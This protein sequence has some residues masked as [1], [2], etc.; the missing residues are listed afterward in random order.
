MP[1]PT[2]PLSSID[3]AHFIGIG[4]IGVSAIA[5]LFLANG[6]AIS[7]SD[8]RLPS[9]SELPPG[10]TY[11]SG[12]DA[13][14]IPS[15]TKLVI[16]SPAV[17]EANPE[18]AR[19][20]ELGITEWSY[21]YALGRVTSA[22]ATI[23]VSGTHGKSTTTALLATM[24][25]DAGADPTAIVGAIVPEWKSNLR[26][27]KS[28]L[29]VVEACEYRRHMLE[30][31][32]QSIVLTN[33][34]LDHPDYYADLADVKRAFKEYIGKL[35][36]GGLLVYNADDANVRDV[37]RGSEA[38][39]VSYGVGEGADLVA[40]DIAE[41]E[42]EQTFSLTWKGSDLGTFR[43]PLPGLYNIYNILAATAA[44]LAYR[45]NT[46]SISTTIER[47]T[48]IGRR[49]EEIGKSREGTRIISDYAHHPTALKNVVAAA[50]TRDPKARLLVIF[51]PHQRE[52][53]LKLWDAFASA[54][55]KA[56]CQTFLLVE[57][58]AVPGREDA[59]EPCGTRLADAVRAIA[60]N[61]PLRFAP[62]LAEAETLARE[63]L[64]AHDI[65]LV[66]GAG[67]IHALAR[68]LATP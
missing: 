37:I 39:L 38:I 12:N 47:F 63:L 68:T 43:T 48:G 45:G 14:N 55:A 10:G 6:V 46:P 19:A 66:V 30:L 53:T 34:E 64:P 31:A 65:A 28:D 40:H 21:P 16:Y 23:A 4:G 8:V 51:Q 59:M 5:R 24:L 60:P 56:D 54:I 17:P 62:S 15:D 1:E 7:G 58:Y 11:F 33:I 41:G 13:A 20:R 22:Y 9:E 42:G 67:D 36:D 35:Q 57:P 50:R 27:G 3:R 49:F 44:C 25:T 61:A 18:R 29:F 26:L 2:T 52:R 32:P